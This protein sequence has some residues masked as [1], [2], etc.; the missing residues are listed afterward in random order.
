MNFKVK[1]FEDSF[2]DAIGA[3]VY[4]IY[5]QRNGD[6]QLLYVGES[7]FV[8]VRCAPHLYEIVKGKGYLGFNKGNLENDNFTIVFKLFSMGPDAAKTKQVRKLKE[9]EVI[10][11]KNPIMQ[12]GISDRVKSIEEMI[13][14][15]TLFLMDENLNC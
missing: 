6:E 1:F 11:E 5:I 2:L 4:E 3:G 7:V 9:K 12:S 14:Q 15:M 8:L 13:N 10:D